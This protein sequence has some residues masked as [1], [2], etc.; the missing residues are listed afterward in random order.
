MFARSK[1][2]SWSSLTV[3]NTSTS[4]WTVS[5]V[6]LL[7][8]VERSV[9][10]PQQ[11]SK[12]MKWMNKQHHW[13]KWRSKLHEELCLMYKPAWEGTIH[14]LDNPEVQVETYSNMV[15]MIILIP[16]RET[17]PSGSYDSE[18][19]GKAWNNYLAIPMSCPSH[20]THCTFQ[21]AHLS[22]KCTTS[23]TSTSSTALQL[24]C[25]ADI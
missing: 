19:A 4:S 5:P 24:H 11:P 2:F 17:V 16:L 8:L 13:S 20:T 6:F 7:G 12:W 18:R 22:F 14:T 1:T 21:G 3:K 9:P 15:I 25:I 23:S 10:S